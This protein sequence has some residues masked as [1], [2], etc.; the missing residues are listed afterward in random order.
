M[1]RYRRV[2]TP[3]EIVQALGPALAHFFNHQTHHR[4]QA[5]S[6]LCSFGHRDLV[7]DLLGYQREAET[8]RS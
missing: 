6:I 5:H 1:I 4:G 2:T 3:D 7:L 8:G